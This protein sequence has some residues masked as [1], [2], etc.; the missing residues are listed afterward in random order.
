M[1]IGSVKICLSGIVAFSWAICLQQASLGFF[2]G[3]RVRSSKK[4]QVSMPSDCPITTSDV[5]LVKTSH[6]AKPS[7]NV[8]G[9]YPRVGVQRIMIE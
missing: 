8:G 9:V 5:P 4:E 2:I 3:C 1:G 6:M 7:V